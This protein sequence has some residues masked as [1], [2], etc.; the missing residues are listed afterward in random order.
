MPLIPIVVSLFGRA[1]AGRRESRRFAFAAD[2]GSA[3]GAGSRLALVLLK[4]VGRKA[5]PLFSVIPGLDPGIQ[6]VSTLSGLPGQ[7]RE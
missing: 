2:D 1:V 7:A 3:A 5:N 6:K 4:A